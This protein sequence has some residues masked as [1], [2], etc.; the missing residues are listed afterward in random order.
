MPDEGTL[1]YYEVLQVSPNAEPDTVHRVYRLLAQRFHPDNR[2]TGSDERFRALQEAYAVLSNPEKRA[3]Y[4]VHHARL[5]RERWRLVSS[6]A[7]S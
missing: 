7:D 6:G 2:E 1:D 5:T 4:D 3:Q